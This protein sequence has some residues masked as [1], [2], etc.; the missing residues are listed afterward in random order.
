MI[1]FIFG[2]SEDVPVARCTSIEVDLPELEQLLRDRDKVMIGFELLPDSEDAEEG[3]EKLDEPFGPVVVW[4]VWLTAG[5]TLDT[6]QCWV[7]KYNDGQACE[8]VEGVTVLEALGCWAIKT[9]RVEANGASAK[10]LKIKP[11]CFSDSASS[12]EVAAQVRVPCVQSAGI[13]GLTLTMLGHRIRAD[14]GLRRSSSELAA[15]G[16]SVYEAIGSWLYYNGLAKIRQISDK[17]AK[18]FQVRSAIILADGGYTT[19]A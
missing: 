3:A 13:I 10:F 7:R 5:V 8:A 11:T 19:E 4:P 18:R 9:G 1:R 15:H 16:A 17:A 14:R 6:S 12:A 2:D